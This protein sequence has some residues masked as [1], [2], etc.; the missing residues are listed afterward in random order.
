MGT[1]NGS[2]G[3]SGKILEAV[4]DERHQAGQFVGGYPLAG[5]QDRDHPLP[6]QQRVDGVWHAVFVTTSFGD[7]ATATTCRCPLA[8]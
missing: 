4:I 7:D 6:Q 1:A 2:D 3:C 8:S 5:L